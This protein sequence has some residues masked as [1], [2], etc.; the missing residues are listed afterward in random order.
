[1]TVRRV[2]GGLNPVPEPTKQDKVR[3]A[4]SGATTPRAGWYW[5]VLLLGAIVGYVIRGF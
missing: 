2:P 4:V 5:A 3:T 1:M